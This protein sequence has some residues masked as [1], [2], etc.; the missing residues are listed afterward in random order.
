MPEP[1]EELQGKDLRI[2]YVSVLAQAHKAASLEQLENSASFV[3]QVS[4]VR[5][6]ALDKINLDNMIDD[7]AEMIGVEVDNINDEETVINI[8]TE[9]AR[10]REEQAQLAQQ[11]EEADMAQ[12]LGNTPVKDPSGE[13]VSALDKLIEQQGGPQLEKI[14]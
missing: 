4:K 11:R 5:E 7:Y 10:M 3:Y 2:E 9:R 8:R 12:K 6:D 14:A 13:D 1:P